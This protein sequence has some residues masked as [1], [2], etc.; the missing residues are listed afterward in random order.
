MV[1]DNPSDFCIL[2]GREDARLSE[3]ERLTMLGGAGLD[4]VM[5]RLGKSLS[6]VSLESFA[7]AL[8]VATLK[9]Q[10]IALSVLR[11]NGEIATLF[12]PPVSESEPRITPIHGFPDGAVLD[13]E[14]SSHFPARGWSHDPGYISTEE[15]TTSFVRLWEHREATSERMTIIAV[16][17]WTMGDQR[18]NSLAFLPGL[19][20]SLGCNV[21]LV[22][23]PFHGR[24]RPKGIPEELPLFPSADPLRTCLAMAHALYDLRI[25]RLFLGRRGHTRISC[26]G[27]SLGAYV[28]ALWA[29]LDQLSR[30]AFLVP[31]VSMGGMAFELLRKQ[32][33]DSLP[34]EFL[35]DLFRDHSPLEREP[36]TPQEAIMVVAGTDD[37]L[38]PKTQICELQTRWPRATVVWAGGGHGAATNRA[39]AFDRI[40][41]FLLA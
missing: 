11:S 14:F 15:N 20:F 21:A 29:S 32:G 27:M 1:K 4:R 10:A 34:L 22:E 3:V 19:L 33:V 30:A 24:R 31:L 16:H 17:G 41:K 2:N 37:H 23:L 36:A 9:T 8:D 38:V 26:V 39:E 25:L 12:A 40:T 7:P 28:G 13:L 6:A 5:T 18:V 35:T